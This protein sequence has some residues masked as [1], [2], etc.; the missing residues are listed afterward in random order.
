VAAVRWQVSRT[1]CPR[2][3][4]A[5][6]PPKLALSPA[7]DGLL[8]WWS[9]S[10]RAYVFIP[11]PWIGSAQS[12]RRPSAH[13]A[14]R[15]CAARQVP[16]LVGSP[17][18]WDRSDQQ[19]RCR[20][21]KRSNRVG[22]YREF[23]GSPRKTWPGYSGSVPPGTTGHW[24]RRP[25]RAGRGPAFRGSAGPRLQDC[26]GLRSTPGTCATFLKCSVTL[27]KRRRPRHRKGPR[28]RGGARPLP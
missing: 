28:S 21:R 14:W 26:R 23:S 15:R 13:P 4:A 20:R 11:R 8:R 5:R 2:T 12:G 9:P 19:T 18:A 27:R 3:A 22:S 16:G 24:T 7:R 6:R 1:P 10:V 17:P 25:C